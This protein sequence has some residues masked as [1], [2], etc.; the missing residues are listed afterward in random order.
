MALIDFVDRISDFLLQEARRRANEKEA[1][2]A[3][4]RATI[5]SEGDLKCEYES[6][7]SWSV[8]RISG[9]FPRPA[10]GGSVK[11]QIQIS[12]EFDK[13][14]GGPAPHSDIKMRKAFR[15]SDLVKAQ[16]SGKIDEEGVRS[17]RQ[18]KSLPFNAHTRRQTLRELL[19]IQLAQEDVLDQSLEKL[20]YDP[21]SPTPEALH[22]FRGLAERLVE[23]P[24]SGSYGAYKRYLRREYRREQSPIMEYLSTEDPEYAGQLG[25]KGGRQPRKGHYPSLISPLAWLRRN[26][27]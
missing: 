17:L 11:A 16:K 5:A 9:S 4:Q 8:L 7:P 25:R 2:P 10:A 20:F 23:P 3:T 1:A 19:A 13:P 14:L 6:W 21:S 15:P 27:E 24:Y 26:S 18:F 22:V 12:L